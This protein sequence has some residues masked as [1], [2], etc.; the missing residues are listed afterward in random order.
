MAK[1][2]L[3]SFE[4][5]SSILEEDYDRLEDR[6]RIA[7][8]KLQK[9]LIEAKGDTE[10][11]KLTNNELIELFEK[12][13]LATVLNY[14]RDTRQDRVAEL[15]ERLQVLTEQLEYARS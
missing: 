1:R 2:K 9:S 15:S 14:R 12:V 11:A 10:L 6:D 4:D 8:L 7:A 3:E 5:L 13:V